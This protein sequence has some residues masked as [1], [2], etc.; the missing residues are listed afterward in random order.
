[1]ITTIT[2]KNQITLPA[3]LV[4]ELDWKPG[5]QIEW[6]KNDDG[7]LIARRKPTRSEL[8]QI[9]GGRGRKYLSAGD[10]PVAE[11]VAVRAREDQEEGLG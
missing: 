9:L 2:G 7:S 10:D 1:M 3:D 6:T 4:R 11:L 8:A 5:H